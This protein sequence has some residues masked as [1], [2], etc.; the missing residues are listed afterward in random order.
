MNRRGFLLGMLAAGVAPAVVKAANIMP[1]FM[2]RESGLLAPDTFIVTGVAN[3]NR[4]L[5]PE[6]IT[7]EALRILNMNID[8]MSR[9][10]SQYDQ[11]FKVGDVITIARPKAMAVV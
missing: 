1:V 3:G 9:V 11:S 7:K 2:R 5:T 8:F 10:N 6:L 4:L